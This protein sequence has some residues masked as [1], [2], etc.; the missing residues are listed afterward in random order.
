MLEM[1]KAQGK[2]DLFHWAISHGYSGN[3]DRLNEEMAKFT[4]MLAEVAPHI[5]P[6]QGEADCASEE[7][8]YA[9]S[10]IDWTEYSHAKR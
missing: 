4:A 8:Q 10:G 9:L 7:V 5:Q 6:W 1:I 3:P 2:L